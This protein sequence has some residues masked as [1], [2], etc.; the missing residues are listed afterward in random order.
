MRKARPG[1]RKEAVI[2]MRILAAAGERLEEL[3]VSLFWT[4]ALDIAR[5][6]S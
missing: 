2:K 4:V 1:Q 6:F 3:L 5:Q